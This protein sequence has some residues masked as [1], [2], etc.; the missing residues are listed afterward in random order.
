MGLT[1]LCSHS[2]KTEREN[3]S[4]QSKLNKK[5]FET[6]SVP[7]VGTVFTLCQTLST[8]FTHIA[9]IST[10]FHRKIFHNHQYG[11]A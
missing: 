2:E 6:I 5:T 11:D 9:E 8:Q 10:K 3:G 7:V 4:N 1:Q